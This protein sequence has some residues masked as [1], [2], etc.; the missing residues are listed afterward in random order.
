[1]ATGII[2]KKTDKGFGFITVDGSDDVFFH[3]SACNG[4][5]DNLQEGQAVQFDIEQGE[6]GPKATNVV[7]AGAESAGAG[8]AGDES[9]AA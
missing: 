2:K 9:M 6:K 3:H 7:A 1:M 4:Q 8:S 5:F